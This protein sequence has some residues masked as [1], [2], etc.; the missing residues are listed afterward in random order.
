MTKAEKCL[1]QKG[2]RLFAPTLQWP[3][4]DIVGI[5]V[6]DVKRTGVDELHHADLNL[7][8]AVGEVRRMVNGVI[9]VA[10]VSRLDRGRGRRS[11]RGS[12]GA[13][14]RALATIPVEHVCTYE[15][16]FLLI[17][18]QTIEC[19][20]YAMS[21]L[22]FL[23]FVALFSA[24][25]ALSS[26]GNRLLVVTEDSAADKEKYSTFWSDL[27]SR[28][29]RL[30]FEAPKNDKLAL[31]K[32]GERAFD[33]IILL[34]T[35]VKDEG[36]GPSLTPNLLL[37]FINNNGNILLALSAESPVPTTISSL[38]LELDI[39]LP[40][41][42]TSL[43][44]DHFNYDTISA[45]EKHDVLVLPKPSP[46]RPDVKSYFGSGG[47]IAFPRAIAQ[48]LGS[49]SQL[50]TPIVR[51]PETAYA[52]NP[53]EESENVAEPFAIG[54]Q[55]SLVS[56]MQARNSARFTVLGSVEALENAWFD[57]TVQGP[58]NKAVKTSNRAFATSLTGWTFMET[59]VLKVGKVEHHLSTITD[60]K[61]GNDSVA[62]LGY[63][64]PKIYR[65]KNDVT[66]NIE[67]SEYSFDHLSPFNVPSDDKLQLE[68]TMLSPFHRLDL[69]P[70]STTL[71]STIFSATFR[72]PDQHGI[73]SFRV[74]YKRPF[75]TNV[76]VKREV[77][78]AVSAHAAVRQCHP[79]AK[80]F[81]RLFLPPQTRAQLTI[82][83]GAALADCLQSSE[84]VLIQRNQ[85]SDCLRPPLLDTL[86]TRCQQLKRGYGECKRGMID[87]RKRFRG[88]QPIAVSKELEGEKPGQ[89]YAGAGFSS[90]N[91]GVK[92]TSG[93]EDEK[94]ETVVGVDGE[95][96][97]VR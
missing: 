27:E 49:S 18:S 76:D 97:A 16:N 9:G 88:N 37:E 86:P 65:I 93:H 56:S 75:M 6:L 2:Q 43:I 4:L 94:V 25:Y 70:I 72:L 50:L 28:G 78:L 34:P 80:I 87:M 51:A 57:R 83:P 92:A 24:V 64:N 89:L 11:E 12:S 60:G 33:H 52:Y 20:W 90:G 66:F 48:E 82:P 54:S 91:D 15:Y 74:N 17:L 73:F 96:R 45:A 8:T 47:L 44:V 81:V 79:L 7:T 13:E 29:Y 62:Q 23:V 36:L 41:D 84:C 22:L 61:S 42:R 26:S 1:M 5:G 40:P 71:N 85:P 31:F 21:R 68:F 63:L 58:G 53:K 35:K 3:W 46:L 59:G 77:T 55:I 67:V 39:H 19:W 69:Q 32:H 95:R 30:A 38:L 14:P 10:S